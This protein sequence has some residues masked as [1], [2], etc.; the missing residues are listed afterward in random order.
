MT[1]TTTFDA[2]LI[3]DYTFIDFQKEKYQKLFQI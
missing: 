1:K 2:N 3:V